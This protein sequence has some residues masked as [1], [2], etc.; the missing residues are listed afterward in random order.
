M[1][2]DSN[3]QHHNHICKDGHRG[4]DYRIVVFHLRI[5]DVIFLWTTSVADYH[6]VTCVDYRLVDT[7]YWFNTGTDLTTVYSSYS[8]VSH[9]TKFNTVVRVDYVTRTTRSA[10]TTYRIP[11]RRTTTIS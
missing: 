9:R 10:I 7:L 4:I 6:F 11:S 8:D 5:N 3:Y 1:V 2:F